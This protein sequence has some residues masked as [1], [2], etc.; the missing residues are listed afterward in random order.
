MYKNITSF[1]LKLLGFSSTFVLAA[2]YGPAPTS[3][4]D[5]QMVIEGDSLTVVDLVDE[6]ADSLAITGT[7]LK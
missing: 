5:D 4:R 1:F 7:E 2:C 6:N 3:Y